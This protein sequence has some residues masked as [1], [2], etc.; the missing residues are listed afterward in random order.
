ME[1]RHLTLT[2]ATRASP[3]SRDHMDREPELLGLLGSVTSIRNVPGRTEWDKWY[4]YL[5][6]NG[7]AKALDPLFVTG[8]N[9]DPRN[10]TSHLRRR[11]NRTS[12]S[13]ESKIGLIG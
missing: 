13:R 12:A 4:A 3:N 8:K 9:S 2:P 10:G 6:S 11:P 1:L 7:L 5:G